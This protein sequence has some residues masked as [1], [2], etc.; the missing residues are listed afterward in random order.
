VARGEEKEVGIVNVNTTLFYV[1]EHG[2]RKIVS[3]TPFVNSCN[4]PVPWSEKPLI[5]TC[6]LM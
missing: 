4:V 5:Y 3:S 1:L 6:V 2:V